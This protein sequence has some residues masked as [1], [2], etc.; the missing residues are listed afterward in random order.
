VSQGEIEELQQALHEAEQNREASL[1][2]GG[3]YVEANERI[4]RLRIAL[5]FKEGANMTEPRES[6]V[7]IDD[8]P[9]AEPGTPEGDDLPIGL[10]VG[11]DPGNL[12]D[13]IPEAGDVTHPDPIGD[14]PHM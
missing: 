9:G 11:R 5:L 2:V 7:D 6:D 12:G 14:T 1:H 8:S 10:R 13:E 4:E 3:A